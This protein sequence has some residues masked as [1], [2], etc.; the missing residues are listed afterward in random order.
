MNKDLKRGLNKGREEAFTEAA[1]K[2]IIK[3]PHFTDEEIADIFQVQV[4]RIA[5]IRKRMPG[6]N[7]K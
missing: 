5:A 3:F 6:I 1:G 4:E 7:S 2:I